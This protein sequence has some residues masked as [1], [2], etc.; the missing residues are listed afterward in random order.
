MDDE[1]E[2]RARIRLRLRQRANRGFTLI[3]L[4]IALTTG[5]AVAGAA[6]I[7]SKSSMGVFEA[8]ARMSQAQFSATMA[9]NRLTSDIQRAGYMSNPN[10]VKEPGR[11]CGPTVNFPNV[12]AILVQPDAS[13]PSAPTSVDNGLTPDRIRIMGNLSTTEL[14]VFRTVQ[15]RDVYLQMDEGAMQRTL[16]ATNNGGPP[17]RE[18]FTPGRYVRLIDKNGKE[19]Y[20]K[21]D[22]MVCNGGTSPCDI[23]AITDVKITLDRNLPTNVTCGAWVGGGLINPLSIVDYW[24]GKPTVVNHFITPATADMIA[25]DLANAAQSGDLN[26]TEL[27]R[28]EMID[29]GAGLAPFPPAYAGAPPASEVVAEYAVDFSIGVT[30]RQ[31]PGPPPE[32][33][34]NLVRY[35][36]DLDAAS[37][38]LLSQNDPQRIASVN[39]RISTRTRAPDREGPIVTNPRARF[40]VFGVHTGNVHGGSGTSTHYARVRTLSQEIALPNLA[41]L[42]W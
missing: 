35:D 12:K 33:N 42:T 14:F 2:P 32:I 3:E 26:R 6:Y 34:P 30:A 4:I 8:E 20:A 38:N 13:M 16:A 11:A 9:M 10:F 22:Q 17:L 5:I 31:L 25:P 1:L 28:T 39:V 36:A 21:I 37:I 41:G 27:V 7:L 40:D 18:L 29:T 24:I 23:A 19:T 15:D